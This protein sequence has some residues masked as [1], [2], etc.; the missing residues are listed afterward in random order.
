MTQHKKR[1][2]NRYDTRKKKNGWY[3]IRLKDC[4]N[5]NHQITDDMIIEKLNRDFDR[6]MK[7]EIVI[8]E[9]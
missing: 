5:N 3:Y 6:F 4:K 1:I 7:G 8:D 2:K 9:N